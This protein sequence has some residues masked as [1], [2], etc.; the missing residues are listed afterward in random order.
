[1]ADTWERGSMDLVEME[2]YLCSTFTIPG[3]L[4]LY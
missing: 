1:M 2:L 4:F 3:S